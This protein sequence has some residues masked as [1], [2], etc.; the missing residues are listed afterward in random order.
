MQIRKELSKEQIAAISSMCKA[1]ISN[2]EIL[3][4]RDVSTIPK[5]K[6]D[7]QDIWNNFPILIVKNLASSVPR[8][9]KKVIN[10][11]NYPIKCMIYN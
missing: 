4:D 2:K 1:E 9:L 11:N 6:T 7:I 8:R 10:M 3:Q 5:F